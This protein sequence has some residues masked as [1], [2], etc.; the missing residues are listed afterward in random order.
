MK[1]FQCNCG[2]ITGDQCQWQGPAREM[3]I[4]EWVPES[5][6]SSHDAAGNSGSYPHNGSMRL[7]VERGCA[8]LI[9]ESDPEWS[10]IVAG[11]VKDYAN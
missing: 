2:T 4:V 1:K 9:V 6:R 7:A 8:D 3:V 11:K 10:R 5:I